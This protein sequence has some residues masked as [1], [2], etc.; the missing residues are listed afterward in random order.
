MPQAIAYIETEIEKHRLQSETFIGKAGDVFIWHAQLYHGG[1]PILDPHRTRRSLVNHY[2]R[3]Q[4]VDSSRV[5]KIGHGQN[6]L[7]RDHQLTS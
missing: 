7:K 6:Y 3:S 2:W 4:D 1:L 5:G